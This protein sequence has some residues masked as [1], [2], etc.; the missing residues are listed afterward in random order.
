MRYATGTGFISRLTDIW[1]EHAGFPEGTSYYRI[2]LWPGETAINLLLVVWQV[3]VG[4]KLDCFKRSSS[5]PPRAVHIENV[6]GECETGNY[7]KNHRKPTTKLSQLYHTYLS[8]DVDSLSEWSLWWL[9][10]SFSSYKMQLWKCWGF[11]IYTNIQKSKDMYIY[12]KYTGMS[13]F[14][15]ICWYN[16]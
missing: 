16:L 9:F 5:P 8:E 12:I 2:P 7:V 15:S 14:L 3:N 6:V 10:F 11:L 1:A 13:T 4:P